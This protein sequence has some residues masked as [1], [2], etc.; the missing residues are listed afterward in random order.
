MSGK[1]KLKK[2][3]NITSEN[4]RPRGSIMRVY[5]H[6]LRFI[7][8]NNQNDYASTL[9]WIH[10]FEQ[11]DSGKMDAY[12]EPQY[13]Y[14]DSEVELNAL[15]LVP[16]R[17]EIAY[18]IIVVDSIENHPE[19][20]ITSATFLAM[21]LWNFKNDF[22]RITVF[23]DDASEEM[24]HS[25]NNYYIWMPK[26]LRNR[27]H[28]GR[29]A[30]IGRP[31]LSRKFLPVIMVDAF[32]L[33]ML[34]SQISIKN[35]VF[36]T[37]N[38]SAERYAQFVEN[39]LFSKKGGR[40]TEAS[41][42]V[43]RVLLDKVL[44]ERQLTALQLIIFA[45]IYGKNR[46]KSVKGF[47]ELAMAEMNYCARLSETLSN[48]I[49]EALENS[50]H[51]TSDTCGFLIIRSHYAENDSNI[52][53][54]K[55]QYGYKYIEQSGKTTTPFAV[56]ITVADINNEKT[57]SETFRK[58]L[59]EEV[60]SYQAD[61][62]KQ[63]T[64]NSL[65][66][67]YVDFK[68]EYLI[69]TPLPGGSLEIENA[70]IDYRKAFPDLH[71]GLTIMADSIS[72]CKGAVRLK[73]ET[74]F[75]TTS[76]A[77]FFESYI[78]AEHRIS[79]DESYFKNININI[80]G[81][82]LSV[83]I[84]ITQENTIT[85]PSTGSE[86][87]T[88]RFTETYDVYVSYFD[89]KTK[90][91][92]LR[93]FDALADILKE[94]SSEKPQTIKEIA[95]QQLGLRLAES[96]SSSQAP[97]LTIF[98]IDFSEATV[99]DK[100][101]SSLSISEIIARALLSD[102]F[103]SLNTQRKGVY[104][105]V[106]NAGTEFMNA[107]KNQLK[108]RYRDSGNT[109]FNGKLQLFVH[110]S[111]SNEAEYRGF[112]LFGRSFEEVIYNESLLRITRGYSLFD[113]NFYK[114]PTPT[115]L[116]TKEPV[117]LIPFDAILEAPNK[118]RCEG[119]ARLILH[120]AI[121]DI[122]N[123]QYYDGGGKL[124]SHMRLGS[125]I[126]VMPF[127][128]IASIFSRTDIAN[129]LAYILLR[130]LRDEGHLNGSLLFYG[131]SDYSKHILNA[132]ERIL[133]IYREKRER[134]LECA[135]AIYHHGTRLDNPTQDVVFLNTAKKA[136]DF[137]QDTTLVQ[138]VPIGSTF[139]TCN[140]MLAKLHSGKEQIFEWKYIRNFAF[141]WVRDKTWECNN[142]CGTDCPSK[143]KSIG[144]KYWKAPDIDSQIL[145]L[146]EDILPELRKYKDRSALL[147]YFDLA[148]ESIWHDAIDCEACYP[149]VG[150]L[151]NEAPLIET[152]ITSTIPRQQYRRRE[153]V[154]KS[155]ERDAENEKRL[156]MLDGFVR[157]GHYERGGLHHQFYIKTDEYFY[158]ASPSIEEWLKEIG[159]EKEN[160]Q[161]RVDPQLTIIFVP[162]HFSNAELVQ[163]VNNYVFNAT[164]TI[165]STRTASTY[166]SNFEIEYAGIRNSI[167][168]LEQIYGT[169]NIIKHVHLC[170]VDDTLKSGQ[171][172]LRA[173]KLLRSILPDSLK[174]EPIV[175]N[176]CFVL[177]DRLS[178]QS[179]E[180]LLRKS[181]T[182]FRTFVHI[183][184]SSLR[185][186]GNSCICCNLSESYKRLFL[187]SSTEWMSSFWVA[188][189]V[190]SQLEL[191][192]TPRVNEASKKLSPYQRLIAAHIINQ[193]IVCSGKK[194]VLEDII[195]LFTCR[196]DVLLNTEF[197]EETRIK[198]ILKT[199]ARPFAT[200]DTEVNAITYKFFILLA[201]AL[202]RVSGDAFLPNSTTRSENINALASKIKKYYSSEDEFFTFFLDYVLEGL[203]DL[204][205]TFLLRPSVIMGL[206][207]MIDKTTKKEENYRNLAALVK[208][209][210][211]TS[212]DESRAARLN[213]DILDG[214]FNYDIK[215]SEGKVLAHYDDFIRLLFIENNRVT[216]EGIKELSKTQDISDAYFL[217]AFKEYHNMQHDKVSGGEEYCKNLHVPYAGLY[218]YIHEDATKEKDLTEKYNKLLQHIAKIA[219][220][221]LPT[222]EDIVCCLMVKDNNGSHISVSSAMISKSIS[223][224]EGC[225]HSALSLL[226]EEY[227]HTLMDYR[228]RIPSDNDNTYQL[229]IRFHNSN[230]V[231]EEIHNSYNEQQLNTLLGRPHAEIS[232]VHL[233]IEFQD[234]YMKKMGIAEQED[235]LAILVYHV[236]QHRHS[237]M[238]LFEAD[239]TTDAVS[240]LAQQEAFA[241]VL[242]QERVLNH[243]SLQA[244]D[245]ILC[246]ANT[247]GNTRGSYAVI[248]MYI[249]SMI[250]LLFR[251]SLAETSIIQNFSVFD[252]VYRGYE[253]LAD[254]NL[255]F[256]IKHA[257]T[258]GF[259][260]ETN[261]DKIYQE[262]LE[263]FFGRFNI[264]S[265]TGKPIMQSALSIYFNNF[266]L[267]EGHRKN[268]PVISSKHA[269]AVI[270]SLL[271]S[272]VKHTAGDNEYQDDNDILDYFEKGEK[273]I[274]IKLYSEDCYGNM[275]IKYLV[276]E[277]I[278]KRIG[279]IPMSSTIDEAYVM[280]LC[281][282]ENL[283][284]KNKIRNPIIG[285]RYAEDNAPVRFSRT[286]S[287]FF[288]RKVLQ[289]LGYAQ[290][291]GEFETMY[292]Y[293]D[294]DKKVMFKAKLPILR[295]R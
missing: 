139:T 148:V 185:I 181:Q 226:D 179:K 16:Y 65:L 248:L 213:N 281:E 59:E 259:P 219:E 27:L 239:F 204:K 83:F 36:Y 270:A 210:V 247:S 141:L 212:T 114:T 103:M 56:E 265:K 240:K 142:D 284:L 63:Q 143:S 44:S 262:R 225:I 86:V 146:C 96:I 241:R 237:L 12:K 260:N 207:T 276:I 218:K 138:I 115:L 151:E 109:L 234:S 122:A 230:L 75:E 29:N 250:G 72:E 127:Y 104:L 78:K 76:E 160:S 288:C 189:L 277:N 4:N 74:E 26:E 21:L 22:S 286:A 93:A 43:G 253:N 190:E 120:K 291:V 121:Q 24:Q 162:E 135:T 287:H 261:H 294:K 137:L 285:L 208:R 69:R 167:E 214:R 147:V 192:D 1:L 95:F 90:P 61:S 58:T 279:K 222:S 131:Y 217:R 107:L 178:A 264:E 232:D 77:E 273:P 183:D 81:T 106:C 243:A 149:D 57:I 116:P 125:K 82:Q 136:E 268:R 166:S 129:R 267:L 228:K 70:W 32:E 257:L 14:R 140:K 258:E 102:G 28:F 280:K 18:R 130:R 174:S 23:M 46:N 8:E 38:S 49:G 242:T 88:N 168:K 184:I 67:Q 165:I 35:G 152:D 156:R 195:S 161:K 211:T 132:I 134:S 99:T 295:G 198:S 199:L 124:R 202:M 33:N 176:E 164:G 283:S 236:L 171:T 30:K 249:N 246:A 37:E 17:Q 85:K 11:G 186:Q 188:K 187:Y 79:S 182:T 231:I 173:N 113:D 227:E 263:H 175:F 128:E 47:E 245:S 45:S 40:F 200:F 51:Y 97:E 159:K 119:N 191:F 269:F 220:A 53:Y 50:V 31:Q 170:F 10:A 101:P 238:K 91:A 158:K 52:N 2:H 150:E 73:S 105:A 163:Y 20:D 193:E 123:K 244:Y 34:R 229:V 145:T 3:S 172:F 118:M 6:I 133:A 80:P 255:N 235:V 194:L 108:T 251:K 274:S 272:A 71:I 100:L 293:S 278:A 224:E 252:E 205:S 206:A 98:S 68:V 275:D 94:I 87:Q 55:S 54:A 157:Y 144:Q 15:R 84:P 180:S 89:V 292:E 223:S 126:H 39:V 290:N 221:I 215:V 64:I 48:G 66:A 154:A 60:K 169:D 209:L 92:T 256:L 216:F 19:T 7:V 62:I 177:V 111:A 155:P 117:A 282:R 25:M 153:S 5:E 13:F 9:A 42:P 254:N 201:S 266:K 41:I 271:V 196:G 197:S 203:C 233:Y 110:D 112:T 289:D